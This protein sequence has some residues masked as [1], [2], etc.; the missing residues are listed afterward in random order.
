MRY[1][2]AF[3]QNHSC[4]HQF[5]TYVLSIVT[6]MK[7]KKWTLSVNIYMKTVFNDLPWQD[8][9]SKDT[10][11]KFTS[12]CKQQQRSC[13]S[14]NIGLDRL[15]CYRYCCITIV[16]SSTFIVVLIVYFI[17]FFVFF[18]S[19][20]LFWLYVSFLTRCYSMFL[21]TFPYIHR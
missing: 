10:R 3:N 2:S 18:V 21:L 13:C 17:L 15:W 4:S 9:M 5:Q 1:L 11:T 14:W 8:L 7:K 6:D 19:V 12:V 16:I 20:L